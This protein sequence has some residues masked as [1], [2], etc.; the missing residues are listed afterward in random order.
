MAFLGQRFNAN[1][2]P[3]GSGFDPLPPGWYEAEIKKAEVKPTKN[4]D[5]TRLNI[6]FTILGPTH[7]GRVVFAGLNIELPS[8]PKAEEIGRQQFGDLLRALGLEEVE[9]SDE[10]VGYQLRIRLKIREQEGYDP[11]NDVNGYKPLEDAEARPQRQAAATPPSRRGPPTAARGAPPSRSAPPART[12]PARARAAAA[13]DENGEE[14]DVPRR[15]V[16]WAG[17]R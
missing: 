12:P 16:P 15:R 4:Q 9:D 1:D 14:A 7:E 3:Q 5:G 17:K 13:E 6:Q 11:T 2:L 8:S 10:L